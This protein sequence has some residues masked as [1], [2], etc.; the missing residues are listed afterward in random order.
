MTETKKTKKRAA[1]TKPAPKKTYPYVVSDKSSSTGWQK[2]AFGIWQTCKNSRFVKREVK[3]GRFEVTITSTTYYKLFWCIK[4]AG[5]GKL[6]V[7]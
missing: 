2:K 3:E 1:R 7:K 4:F 6:E 5:K